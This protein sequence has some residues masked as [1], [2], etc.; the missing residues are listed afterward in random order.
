[1][2]WNKREKTSGLKEKT[3]MNPSSVKKKVVAEKGQQ[4]N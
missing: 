3:E 4:P 2:C 1:M